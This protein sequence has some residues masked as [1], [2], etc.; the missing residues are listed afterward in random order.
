MPWQLRFGQ[1]VVMALSNRLQRKLREAGFV[2]I[3]GLK[4]HRPTA[5]DTLVKFSRWSQCL[6]MVFGTEGEHCVLRNVVLTALLNLQDEV[7][8]QVTV[9]V[10]VLVTP[11]GQ[12]WVAKIHTFAL[13]KISHLTRA[14][15]GK[16]LGIDASFTVKVEDFMSLLA[17]NMEWYVDRS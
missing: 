4:P 16:W 2:N 7:G 11:E 14:I 13:V 9:P 6:T 17:P 15:G 10:D 12:V 3:Q 5:N 8:G 1:E